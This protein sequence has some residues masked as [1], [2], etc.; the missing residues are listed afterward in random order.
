MKS[1]KKITVISIIAVSILFAAGKFFLD[2]VY[3][4]AILMYHSVCPA[5][6]TPRGYRSKLNVL[7]AAF[8][9][10]MKFLHDNNYKVIGLADFVERIKKGEKIPHKTVAIT[11][12]DG[13]KNN[14]LY[15]YP[16][17]KKYNFPAIMFVPSGAVGKE[18]YMNWDDIRAMRKNNISIGSHTVTQSWLPSLNEKGIREELA[19]SKNAIERATGKPVKILSYPVGAF[20]ERVKKIAKET[21]YTGAVA[22][23]PGKKYSAADSYALKRIRISMTSNNMLV[24]WIETSGYYTF[25]KEHRDED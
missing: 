1:Y 18:G 25:I 3:V 2:S 17:L 13:L 20:D 8:E 23:N 24:F 10:Q 14:F 21:G 6:E 15:A 7:P 11:F 4:P 5:R 16:V 22:T 9:R 19:G 12:D